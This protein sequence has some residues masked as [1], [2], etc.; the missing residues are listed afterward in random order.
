MLHS[1]PLFGRS[2]YII[3]CGS[4]CCGSGIPSCESPGIVESG[5]LEDDLACTAVLPDGI[6]VIHIL[7][8][9][10][11]ITVEH[12]HP[13]KH[14]AVGINDTG[15]FRSSVITKQSTGSKATD[16]KVVIIY[17]PVG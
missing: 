4:T 11:V 5:L 12:Q 14:C 1:G 8:R 16:G 6:T 13:D 9:V 3:Q 15:A 7:T 10:V 17:I 2:D